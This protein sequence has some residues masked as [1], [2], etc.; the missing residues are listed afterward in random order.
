MII[1]RRVRVRAD[2]KIHRLMHG[3]TVILVLARASGITGEH[4]LTVTLSRERAH[5]KHAEFN[6]DATLRPNEAASRLSCARELSRI[7]FD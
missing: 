4:A 2:D 7:N 5:R 6:N 3:Q 1:A